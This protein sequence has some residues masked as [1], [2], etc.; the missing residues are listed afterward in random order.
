M[1]RQT[2]GWPGA[3]RYGDAEALVNEGGEALQ[4]G[5]SGWFEV[6][7]NFLD[8]GRKR[9]ELTSNGFRECP[10]QFADHL[11]SQTR[12]RPFKQSRGRTFHER[13]R[14]LNGH[15]IVFF[16]RRIGVSSSDRLSSHRDRIG[17]CLGIEA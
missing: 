10:Q 1:C 7:N 15:A 14:Q 13:K 12:H 11:L 9:H 8:P 16:T 17:K 3:W 4:E 6:P 5:W 2:V